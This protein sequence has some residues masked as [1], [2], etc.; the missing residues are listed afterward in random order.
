MICR[1]LEILSLV[2]A[3]SERIVVIWC[4]HLRVVCT[5]G[6]QVLFDCDVVVD[7]TTSSFVKCLTRSVKA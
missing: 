6:T 1:V 4:N 3:I 7:G 2:V 5:I